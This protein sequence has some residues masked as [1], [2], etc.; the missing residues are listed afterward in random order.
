M[1]YS[2]GRIFG[3]V[4]LFLLLIIFWGQVYGLTGVSPVPGFALSLVVLYLIPSV[5]EYV[6]P[7][8]LGVLMWVGSIVFAAALMWLVF[9]FKVAL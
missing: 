4:V 6:L 2:I 5:R 8:I 3:P 1:M 7:I 9:G